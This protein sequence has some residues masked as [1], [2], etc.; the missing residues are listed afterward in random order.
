MQQQ[1]DERSVGSV[2]TWEL[3][4]ALLFLIFGSVVMGDSWHIGARWGEDGP[5]AG[6]FP[7]YV[8]LLIVISAIAI[9]V[10]AVRMPSEEAREPFVRWGQ[11]KMVLVVFIPTIIYVFLIDNPWYS[12]GIYEPSV[13][14]MAVFMRYLG[15]YRWHTIA[16]VSIGV[17]VLFFLMFEIWFQVPLPKGPIEAALGY[18]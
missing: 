4:V 8:G 14:F 6:Y 1:S 2:R 15:K 16:L 17:M 5:Q 3:V 10:A 12:L 7:F 9:L 11:L 18:A 13:L